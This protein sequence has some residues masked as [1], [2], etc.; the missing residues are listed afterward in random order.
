MCAPNNPILQCV[1][2]R[3]TIQGF[4]GGSIVQIAIIS[5]LDERF[6][7]VCYIIQAW[8]NLQYTIIILCNRNIEGENFCRCYCVY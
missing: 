1:N 3:C 5:R 4:Q 6:F 7:S 8:I 2:I